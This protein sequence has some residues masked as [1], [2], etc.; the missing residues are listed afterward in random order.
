LLLCMK[1]DS[2]PITSSKTPRPS[3]QFAVTA[4]NHIV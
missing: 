2:A 1:H 4:K 3:K